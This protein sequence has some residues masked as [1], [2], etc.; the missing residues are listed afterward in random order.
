MASHVVF[1]EVMFP[2]IPSPPSSLLE[3]GVCISVIDAVCCL[4]VCCLSTPYKTLP[5]LP[6]LTQCACITG[7]VVYHFL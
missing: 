1:V 2:A 7:D 3:G 6:G 4:T 5:A